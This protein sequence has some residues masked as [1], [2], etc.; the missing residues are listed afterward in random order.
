MSDWRAIAGIMASALVY[1]VTYHAE[2]S[3]VS[4]G[5]AEQSRERARAAVEDYMQK[6]LGGE[7]DE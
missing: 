7:Q 6:M 3:G 1:A 5:S 2:R 4:G